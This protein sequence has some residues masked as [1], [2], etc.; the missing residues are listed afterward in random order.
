M[1]LKEKLISSFLAFENTTEVDTSFHQ[2]RSEAFK[3][4]EEHGFPSKKEE[5]WKYTS[6]R[7]VLKPDYKIFNKNTSDIDLNEV[8]KYFLHEID[9]Y[10][11]VFVDGNYNSFL[12]SSTHEGMDICVM[13]SA[14][15]K[16]KYK[17]TVD[18]YFNK[19]VN[20]D[21]HFAN[22]NTS[23]A[24]EGAFINIPKNTIVPKPI[25][26]IY[27]NTGTDAELMLQPRN[28]V[29]VGENSHV[30][31]IER[32]QSLKETTVLTNTATEIFAHKRAIVDYYKI[33]N[34]LETSSHIDNTFVSQQKESVVSVNTY[35]FGGKFTRNNLEFYQEDER[36]TSNLNGFTLIEK[37]QLVDNHTLVHHKQ[38]NCESHELYKGIY[39]EKSTGIFNGKIIVDQLAQK[40]NAFQQSNNMLIDNE[41][42]INAK[43][44]L[45]IFADDVKCSHGCTI[46]QLDDKAIF[47]LRSRGIPEKEAKALMLY[48]FGN[49]V[50]EK[51]KIPE[52]K[53]RITRIIARKLQVDL[54]LEM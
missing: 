51:I 45:E 9:T 36:I 10:K 14:I 27:F 32:H 26:I 2:I 53:E 42:S 31:I 34:D 19:I 8:R 41:A 17:I 49:D 3:A 20:K 29:V 37:E 52:L 4:F 30:Q 24:K 7:E 15:S 54:G 43:P 25:E 50:L 6:L 5:E 47:Y 21:A 12:S 48:A 35:S 16:P 38:P 40:T 13:S 46:G 11:L 22:L 28:L 39:A 18:Y 33:Q 44:Q 23:F 1:D